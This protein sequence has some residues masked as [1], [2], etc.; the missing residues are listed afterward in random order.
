MSEINIDH[1]LY[2]HNKLRKDNLRKTLETYGYRPETFYQV[3][4]NL[5]QDR[6]SIC[7]RYRMDQEFEQDPA[8]LS[9]PITN[10]M[11]LLERN[12]SEIM[13][14]LGIPQD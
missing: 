4:K 13:Q 9:R 10:Y 8:V 5:L 2:T 3:I 1:Q 6:Y 14:A 7:Q 11:D 12:N